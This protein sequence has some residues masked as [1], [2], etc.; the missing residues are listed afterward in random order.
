MGNIAKL[1][2]KRSPLAAMA[3]RLSID[4]NELQQVILKTVM[5]AGGK[6][7]TNEQ[8]ISFLAVANAYGLDP[9]KREIFAFPAKGGGIQPIVSIDGWL[10]I[11]NSHPQF[12]GMELVENHDANGV[13][14]SVTCTIHRKDR[15]HPTVVTEWLSECKQA[16]DPWT[17]KPRRMTRH[18]A[19]IQCS[20]YAF[21]LGGIMDE[22]DAIAAFGGERDVSPTPTPV[23]PAA[24]PE[25]DFNANLPKWRK[26]IEDGKKTPD[27]IIATVES[28]GLLSESQKEAVRNLAPIPAE[29]EYVDATVEEFFNDANA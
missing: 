1:D 23:G 8:L 4:P 24:Y 16:T 13:F 18:K 27:Q 10:S 6:D 12:D 21:G 2:T 11:I 22:D 26:L 7:V 3:E 9:L 28:K 15:I 25:A 5:P 19:S 14:E 17:K 20:R 29:A